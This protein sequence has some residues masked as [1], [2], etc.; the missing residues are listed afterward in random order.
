[1]KNDRARYNK[2][3]K[4]QARLRELYEIRIKHGST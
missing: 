2:D 1:M 4:M 3:E